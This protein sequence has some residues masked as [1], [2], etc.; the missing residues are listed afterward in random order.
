[1]DNILSRLEKCCIDYHTLPKVKTLLHD[2]V[3]LYHDFGTEL[4]I[5]AVEYNKW[6]SNVKEYHEIALL[7]TLLEFDLY[8]KFEYY[9]LY[10]H[11]GYMDIVIDGVEPEGG[12]KIYVKDLVGLKRAWE[13]CLKEVWEKEIGKNFVYDDC[14]FV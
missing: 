13:K 2:M 12:R 7:T 14:V 4:A 6:H 11:D 9:I 1:M 5:D 8:V 10:F 3:G